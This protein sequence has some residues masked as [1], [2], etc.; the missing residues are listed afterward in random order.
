M[1]RGFPKLQENLLTAKGH[2]LTFCKQKEER[3]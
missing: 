1:K 2:G 3:V